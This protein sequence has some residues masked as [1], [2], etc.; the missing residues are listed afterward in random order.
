M[1]QKKEEEKLAIIVQGNFGASP[2]C[3]YGN[4]ISQFHIASL[5]M[6]LPIIYE[7]KNKIEA[8]KL[9]NQES[10]EIGQSI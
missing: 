2:T 1:K 6:I 7:I 5:L 9:P 8:F 3:F 10:R 4:K